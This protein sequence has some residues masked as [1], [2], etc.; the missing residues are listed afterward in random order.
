[1]GI[2]KRL[3]DILSA[4][5]NHLLDRAADPRV[6][7]GQ[8]VRELTDAVR[9]LRSAVARAVASERMIEDDIAR[10]RRTADL[11]A[12]RAEWAV[13]RGE[14]DL[15]RR[16]LKHKTEQ[17]ARAEGLEDDRSRAARHT[18]KL[19]GDLAAVEQRLQETQRRLDELAA[20]DTAARARRTAREAMA[21]ASDLD[22]AGELDRLERRVRASEFED[23]ALRELEGPEIDLDRV[24]RQARLDEKIDEELKALKARSAKS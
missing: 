15:A 24:V 16:S 10:C 12:E 17:L 9:T 14:D 19:R 5:V 20:R 8:I 11:W 3:S 13:A 21:S 2:F 22:T 7:A 23:E 6:M 4:N 18:E 1:M